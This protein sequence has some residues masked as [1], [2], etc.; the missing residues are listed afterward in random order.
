MSSKKQCV[1]L[2]IENDDIRKIKRIS[3]RLNVCGSDL[4]RVAIKEILSKLHPLS[5][6]NSRGARLLPVFLEHESSITSH[7]NLDTERLD[8]IINMNADSAEAVDRSDIELIAMQSIFPNYLQTRL[9][10]LL[11][12]T[13]TE[14]EL[15]MG[16]RDYLY[17]KYG[18]HATKSDLD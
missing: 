10:A 2:R 6:E 1:S 9:E 16:L 4:I 11:A 14:T 17:G 18:Q 12:R 7:F 13:I 8:L 3:E 5:D 15:S